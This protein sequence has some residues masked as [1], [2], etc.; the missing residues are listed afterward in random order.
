MPLA[1]AEEPALTDLV[2]SERRLDAELDGNAR[3]AFAV[4]PK[5]RQKKRP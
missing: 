3:K 1:S 4:G 5:N 2:G